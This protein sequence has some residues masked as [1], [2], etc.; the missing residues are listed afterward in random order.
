MAAIKAATGTK[1]LCRGLPQAFEA[2]MHAVVSLRWGSKRLTAA[3]L[4]I[5]VIYNGIAQ[6][7]VHL[8]VVNGGRNPILELS[9]AGKQHMYDV[10]V[11][12]PLGFCR[13]DEE[14][15]YGKYVAMFQPLLCAPLP[16]ALADPSLQVLIYLSIHVSVTGQPH[17]PCLPVHCV[18]ASASSG[19]LRPTA[20]GAWTLC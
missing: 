7:E 12:R 9:E 13:Y 11:V 2:F 18:Y 1:Q 8:H 19:R 4:A 10:R 3:C 20:T 17:I 6:L 14:P 15:E 5:V 16:V